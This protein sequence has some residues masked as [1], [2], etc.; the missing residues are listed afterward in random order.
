MIGRTLSRILGEMPGCKALER[1][2]LP[3]EIRHITH[4]GDEKK[5]VKQYFGPYSQNTLEIKRVLAK[6]FES[7]RK[8]K[9]G[10]PEF[11]YLY[12]DEGFYGDKRDRFAYVRRESDNSVYVSMNG[13]IAGDRLKYLV[14]SSEEELDN[15]DSSDIHDSKDLDRLSRVHYKHVIF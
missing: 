4:E 8:F 3:L 13:P 5:I 14:S 10:E 15:Y 9:I 2:A 12:T 7:R 1:V 11:F 6:I